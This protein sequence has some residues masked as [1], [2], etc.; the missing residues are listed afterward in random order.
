MNLD[1]DHVAVKVADI[2]RVLRSFEELGYPNSGKIRYD[3]VGMDIAFLGAG[4]GKLE[5][6]QAVDST[7]PV[8]SAPEGLH[9]VAVKVGDI[10]AAHTRMSESRRFIV[11]G[12][13]R[14]GA[15]SRIFFFRI[16][17]EDGTLYECVESDG[18]E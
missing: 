13:V 18:G 2:D 15:H 1:I 9:H 6:L 7:S 8:F 14:P 3:E 16:A 5:L 11:E 17:G 12:P 4:P 10:E